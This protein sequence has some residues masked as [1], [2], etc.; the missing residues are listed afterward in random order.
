MRWAIVIGADDYG[1][2]EMELSAAADDACDF[3][4]WV[5][6]GGGVPASNVRLLLSPP[7]KDPHPD[8]DP[9]RR[10]R[11]ATKD[12]I[13]SAINEVVVATADQKPERLYFYF[14]GHGITARVS[15]RD[16]SAIVL[17]GFDEV[18]PD[19][20]LAVRSIAE[21]FET[22]S[23]ADQFL[24]IDAC[25][26][27]P[28]ANR[29]LEIGRWPVPRKR[30]PGAPPTQQFILYATAPGHTAQEGGWLGEQ[31]GRFTGVLLEGLAGD[32]NAK[33]WSWERNC[34][35]VRWE[36]L[37]SF[38]NDGMRAKMPVGIA[39]ADIQAQI[40][41]DTGTRGVANRERDPVV[42]S[43][44]SGHFDPATLTVR[45]AVEAKRKKAQVSVLDALGAPV[46]SALGVTGEVQAFQLPPKTYAV[47]ATTTTP[48]GLSGSAM[49]PI[50]LYEDQPVTIELLPG[51]R[52]PA[53]PSFPQPEVTPIAEPIGDMATPGSR[54]Q[55]GATISIESEDS[56]AVAEIVDEA[57]RVCAVKRAGEKA[58]VE[59]G[60]YYVRQIGPD[61]TRD[62]VF[63]RLTAGES[64]PVTLKPRAP[65]VLVKEL[66]SAMGGRVRD[67]Y[68]TMGND[69]I[70]WAQPTTVVT[71]G[72]AKYLA[73]D[74]PAAMAAGTVRAEFGNG[75]GVAVFA[76]GVG[77]D[78]RADVDAVRHVKVAIW[79][80]G[81][82]VVGTGWGLQPSAAGVAGRVKSVDA[83][84][85][86]VSFTAP[87][88]A[89]MVVA[90]PVLPQRLATLVAQID[91]DR[92]R[93]YQ[94][95]PSLAAGASA[96]V[97]R[98]W[99][100]EYLQ[101][102]LLAGRIDVADR[103][104]G[105]LAATAS[106]DPFAGV[107]AGYVLLRLGLHEELGAL[108][109]AIITA[110][111]TL[112]DAY[113]LRAEDEALKGHSELAE[114]AFINA[115]DCGIP[116]FGEGMTR[117]L[118][119]LRHIRLTLPRGAV[120]R[121]VFQR[122]VRGSMWAAFTPRRGLERGSAVISSADLGLEA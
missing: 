99:R 64:E 4:D 70:A 26:N 24:F 6:A 110:A 78:G 36:R 42:V 18:H 112:S 19:H 95:H 96:N 46:A 66:A 114:Q 62:G 48:K 72:L 13:V 15:N 63:V 93:L 107:V 54:Q 30:D 109:S 106:E 73:G 68:L 71:A 44:P 3:R 92:I 88:A 34:Y 76:V 115:V 32:K 52:K 105:E 74:E 117:L 81:E 80:A 43:F 56:L 65:G 41:Q 79:R 21:Y 7:S 90:L 2:P 82:P 23:F 51:G 28:W 29:E 50:E 35:E 1:T 22:T 69:A 11:P 118:E 103:L 108:A 60:F 84:P 89:P 100:I 113:I 85:H 55:P 83:A 38:I 5:I 59:P 97:S 10:A 45:L 98:L 102:M 49:A 17:P 119:G 67:G 58:D 14:A 33:A 12:N 9:G 40:P 25:R 31:E 16:E 121:H 91:I 20:S 75:S 116:A 111:P 57:G 53:G 77:R 27:V 104:A 39:E 120:V 61:G 101:R 94:Y 8:E 86:W 87:G 122:H 47:Q 37:A